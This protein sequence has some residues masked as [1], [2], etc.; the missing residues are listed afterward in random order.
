MEVSL[1]YVSAGVNR[2]VNALSWGEH[3][4]VAY[5]A[6]HMVALYDVE[7]AKVLATLCGHTGMVNCVLWVPRDATPEL[8]PHQHLLLSGSA[9]A[10][11][12]AWLVSYARAAG[13]PAVSWLCL[14]ELRGHGGPVTS[15]CIH[16]L[17]TSGQ[18]DSGQPRLLLV[19]TAGDADVVVW[20]CGPSVA[21]SDVTSG[22]GDG[23]KTSTSGDADVEAETA[24]GGR[25]GVT[26]AAGS[27]EGGAK[28]GS[29]DG[30]TADA[31]KLYGD[32]CWWLAQR[33]H[34]GTRMQTTAA[35]THLPLD[36][37]W[38]VLAMGGTDRCVGLFVRPPG[39]GA[40][41]APACSL[42]GH[43]NWVRGVAWCHVAPA[44]PGAPPQLL[45]ASVSQDRYGRIW[46][47]QPESAAA[48]AA[49]AGGLSAGADALV[50]AIQRYAPKPHVDT[51]S[52]RYVATPEALLIGHED[53]VHSLA[54]APPPPAP[55]CAEGGGGGEAGDP[56]RAGVH[57]RASAA[58]L[59]ASMDRTMVVWRYEASSGL[60]M[61]EASLGDAGA[62]CLGYYGGVWG[63]R[64]GA[65]LAH[66]FTGALHLWRQPPGS[67]RWAP[68]HA[69]GGH[70]GEVVDVAWAL[71][72]GCVL[73]VGGDQ[74]A[75]VH[76][77]I[78]VAAAP[79][80][81]AEAAAG[82]GDGGGQRLHWCEI[83]RSQVH[84]HDFACA[85][86]VPTGPGSDYVYVAGSEEKV[87]RVME[88]PQAFLD[89]LLALRGGEATAAG[90]ALAAEGRRGHGFGAA[91]AALG[92]SNKALYEGEASAAA[93][94]GANAGGGGGGLGGDY[95]DGPDFV[96]NAA[97]QVI[98]EPPLEEHLAQNTLWP[99]T[100]KLYG[101]GNDVFCAAASP[102][103]RFVASACKAQTAATAAV[104]V[105]C[106]RTWR[107]LGQLKA[108][109]LTVTQL[110]WSASG[111]FLAAGSRDRTFSIFRVVDP[112]A[113]SGPGSGAG[114]G[115]N[116]PVFELVCRTK[117]AHG[118]IIWSVSWSLDEQLLATASRDE[119]VKVWSTGCGGGGGD[120]SSAAAEP[121]TPQLALTLPQF[122][123]AATA[124]AFAPR[125]SPSSSAGGGGGTGGGGGSGGGYLLAVGLES[126][127]VQLWRLA[128][129]VA[130]EGA[131]LQAACVW[132]AG[133]AWR[134]VA[135]VRRLR[136]RGTPGSA[137]LGGGDWGAAE[138][139]LQLASGSE[140]HT[141]RVLTFR[142]AAEEVRS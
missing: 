19:S 36:P 28:L 134:H 90:R 48:P 82:A 29:A 88:A 61:N 40:S 137:G 111:R 101:H 119:T 80:E 25:G 70:W 12:R 68:S 47:L 86:P 27:S 123:C 122:P 133:P 87:L 33:I 6:H 116:D 18:A 9:D 128:E 102:D 141:V 117:A 4:G 74:T 142:A 10:T 23:A 100:Q 20:E 76:T 98:R 22:T 140:D 43:E 65:I 7:A 95:T 2:V 56:G 24:S 136:W 46:V 73:S 1:D 13:E 17:P 96:P 115:G 78:I 118:R 11:I 79:S 89:T 49:A 15:L 107:P 77:G 30:P 92:L 113:R 66:G 3:G 51:A 31:A 64:G 71:D 50:A 60:W 35:M 120:A 63:P 37:D 93:E 59:T 129:V 110:E 104:W 135:P 42:E 45:L 131:L 34:V 75:R 52:H 44:G 103:G 83:A 106:A 99:E 38:T 58:L 72:G 41:F 53:W 67:S 108:H 14:G 5:A 57:T 81:H 127:A 62:S 121:A 139:P 26:E 130:G 125:S 8:A 85:A 114:G 138:G 105:W 109:T 21:T 32:S 97:P 94:A 16:R 55:A 124:V 91:V 126:G 39:P 84:G 112:V 54:W 132:E 69:L